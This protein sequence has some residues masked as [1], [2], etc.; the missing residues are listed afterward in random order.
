[1]RAPEPERFPFQALEGAKNLGSG[2][3]FDLQKIISDMQKPAS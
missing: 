3:V 2:V 1:M